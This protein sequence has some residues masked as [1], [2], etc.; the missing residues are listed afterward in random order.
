MRRAGV[1]LKETELGPKR[2]MGPVFCQRAV[3]FLRVI[4]CLGGLG[5]GS[6][7]TVSLVKAP[8]LEVAVALPRMVGLVGVRDPRDPGTR[9][10]G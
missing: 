8:E 7:L 5:G 3:W 1:E 4:E 10:L 9:V 2:T 6:C